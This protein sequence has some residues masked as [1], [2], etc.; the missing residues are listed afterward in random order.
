MECMK[1]ADSGLGPYSQGTV[2]IVKMTIPDTNA[3]VYD[4]SALGVQSD[5]NSNMS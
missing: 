3:E 5:G 1:L 2:N 4:A